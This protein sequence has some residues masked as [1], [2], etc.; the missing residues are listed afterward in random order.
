MAFLYSRFPSRRQRTVAILCAV[1]IVALIILVPTL[2]VLNKNESDRKRSQADISKPC[3]IKANATY[4]WGLS[5]SDRPSDIFDREPH[6]VLLSV[7]A[8]NV[9]VLNSQQLKVRLYVLPMGDYR[10][11]AGNVKYRFNITFGSSTLDFQPGLSIPVSNGDGFSRDAVINLDGDVNKYPFD[12][13]ESIFDVYGSVVNTTIA[14]QTVVQPASFLVVSFSTLQ[15]YAVTYPDMCDLTDAMDG[16]DVLVHVKVTRAVATKIYS[17]LIIILCWVLSIL[18]MT[19]T[20]GI[21]MLDR[22]VEPPIIAASGALLFALPA[23]R[24]AQPLVP[25]IGSVADSV[26]FFWNM[27]LCGLSTTLLLVNYIAK[28]NVSDKPKAAPA[29]PQ[30]PAPVPTSGGT[31]PETVVVSVDGKMV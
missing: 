20:V 9:D 27:I 2:G 18:I 4:P 29:K 6:A 15:G 17:I 5:L 16:T 13:W 8:S 1:F 25:P 19:A 28:Y 23:I 30:T 10:T 7:Q 22:K 3:N 21:W 14:N 12:T 26:G 11:D 24:N 31:G